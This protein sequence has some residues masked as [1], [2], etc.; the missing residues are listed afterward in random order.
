MKEAMLKN[1]ITPQKP[2]KQI[3]TRSPRTNH[4]STTR[5]R[6]MPSFAM[7][8]TTRTISQTRATLAPP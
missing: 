6:K 2:Q 7:I 3:H 1:S 5:D 4:G 8:V